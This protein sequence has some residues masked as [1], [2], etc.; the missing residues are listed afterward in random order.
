ML[1]LC[2]AVMFED[3]SGDAVPIMYLSMLRNIEK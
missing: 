3:S 1:D 2:G